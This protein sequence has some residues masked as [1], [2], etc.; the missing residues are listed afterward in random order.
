ME[1]DKGSKRQ[2]RCR[3]KMSENAKSVGK[4]TWTNAVIL[5]YNRRR[6]N[7]LFERERETSV[8]FLSFL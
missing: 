7:R 1:P 5:L 2:G 3:V 6:R 4:Q 8:V